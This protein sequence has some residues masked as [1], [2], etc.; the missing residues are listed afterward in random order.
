MGS[1]NHRIDP[2]QRRYCNRLSSQAS[3]I[4]KSQAVLPSSQEN[5]S[6]RP[7]VTVIGPT[8][9]RAV[10]DLAGVWHTA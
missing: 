5:N 3:T 7:D 1:S 6:R 4:G 10:D 2:P 9:Y 8:A